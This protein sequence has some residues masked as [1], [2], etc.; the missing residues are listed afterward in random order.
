[1]LGLLEVRADDGTP[2]EI[3]GA[4][5]RTLLIL[6]ALDP[7]RVVTSARLIDGV[8]GADP[9][10]EA[11]N[12]LQ[13]LVSRLRRAL[14]EPAVE[15]TP[16]GYRLA[17]APDAVD[18]HGFEQLAARG[19]AAL[20]TD[21]ERAA[22]ALREA[23][24]L[25]R[26]P[27]LAD[28][29]TAA[30][31]QAPLARLE[32]L[33]LAVRGDRIEAELPGADGAELVA[34]LEELVAEHP[35][36]ERF[37]GLLMR[38]LGRAGRGGDALAVYAR[39]RDALADELGADP[40]ADLA[41]L[42]LSILR[43]G[44]PRQ[45][46][47][48]T[49]LRAALTSFVGRDTDLSRVSAMVGESRLVTLT[50]PGGSGK[51]RLA[52]E[53]GRALLPT[54]PDVWLVELAPV[55]DGADLPQAVVSALGLRM[56]ALLGSTL[57]HATEPE[58]VD[59]LDRLAAALSTRAMLLVLDNCE[60]LIGPAAA[61]ANRLLGD[62][63]R[64][65]VLA[66][67]REPLGITGETLWPV[68]PL[69]LPPAGASRDQAMAYPSMRLLADR[70]SAVR[71]GF[72]VD[73]R[74]GLHMIHVCRAL[75]GMPLAI[76]LAAARL[77]T[78]TAEQVA[79]RLDDRFR[80][81][82]GGSRLALPRHQT[83]R[84]VVDW[85]WDLLDDAERALLRRLAVF[86]GGA[87]LEA[88]EQVCAGPVLPAEQVFDVLSALV[89][90]SLVLLAGDG[91]YRMLETI[92][93]Y[94]LERLA[95]AGET[96]RV[97][98]AHVEHF[99]R[100]A[101]TA[102]PYLRSAEQLDWLGRLDAD[103][104]NL[105]A[106]LRTAIATGQTR[107]AEWF[108]ANLGWYWWLHGHKVEGGELA[109]E[110]LAMTGDGA[111]AEV[112]AVAYGMAALLAADGLRDADKALT[113][114]DNAVAAAKEVGPGTHPI[115][116]LIGPLDEVRNS[117]GRSAQPMGLEVIDALTRDDDPWLRGTAQALRAH[118]F[119]NTGRRH[120]EA[121]AD[122]RAALGSFRAVGERWGMS[123]ASCSLADMIAW[124]GDLAEAVELYQEA[125][126][127]FSELVT[128]EDLTRY[129]LRLADLL[130]NLGRTAESA[131]TL[132]QARRA[133]D[134]AGMPEG[135][136]GVAHTA[137]EFAR[138]RGD[139]DTARADLARATKLA[140][141]VSVPPQFHA[142]IEASHGYLATAEG[143][144]VA[145]AEHHGTAF[146]W[147]LRSN[148]AP[149]VAHALVGLAEVSLERG[150]VRH[151]AALLGASIAIRG[152]PD[153]SF[154]DGVRVEAATRAALGEE[155]FAEAAA[156]GAHATMDTVKELAVTPA[157]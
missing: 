30:F 94:G 51:T 60:H 98:W 42:H 3:T 102:E 152:V 27:A 146:E 78:M 119:L 71:P 116:R 26:G 157:V 110:V 128:N 19:R 112:R 135:L 17:V 76:E 121:E 100:L 72:T 147:A 9:P 155:P 65:R 2:V 91:H 140:T 57:A 133:A 59:P 99:G 145:A 55:S 48:H 93:A 149:V 143:D 39:I 131:A 56:P 52:T 29:A 92:K 45:D 122:F 127:L 8:W 69:P 23:E 79:T 101:E 47:P 105:N 6:L 139:L 82:T 22:K 75:D 40:S 68:D 53:V 104:D 137:G 21:P 50:G 96:D 144:P 46:R 32:A 73:D 83:L 114:F 37:A 70:A 14:P 124:R 130:L 41:E 88:A 34:E 49:N 13:A 134:R 113:F 136:A 58:A 12:A 20:R 43:D 87:T 95:E 89:D 31:A 109:A 90:K 106:A 123:F 150:D 77:R 66:T 117:F 118:E 38:G 28:V 64:L 148:D 132:D 4:R 108:L 16:A 97:R 80:L 141:H 24:A 142:F 67:S 74:T 36:H 115:I 61:L 138:R 153:R 103:K 126:S 62:C 25:C 15:S 81:L 35:L 33:V 7:G 129:R 151:A 85:S 120:A 44:A 18:L 111:P 5:L 1:M 125:I 11:T 154:A 84:A 107:T 10:A 54:M 156:R 63:P 86:A